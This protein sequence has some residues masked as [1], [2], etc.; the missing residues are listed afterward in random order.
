MTTI[1]NYI[2]GEHLPWTQEEIGWPP[3]SFDPDFVWMVFVDRKMV[4]M[5]VTARMMNSV[6][7]VRLL[8]RD[9]IGWWIR[10]LWSAVRNVCRN[11]GIAGFWTCMDNE[12]EP[13]RKLLALLR[14]GRGT[15]TA[16]EVRPAT[17]QWITG[18][19]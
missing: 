18:R 6:L 16:M 4:A 2:P 11:R 12:R 8:S 13:E 9:R 10:P 17:G 15:S 7:L 14:A 5:L 1:R 3:E 19:F